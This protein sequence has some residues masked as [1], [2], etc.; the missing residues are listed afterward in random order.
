[1][2]SLR[3]HLVRSVVVARRM[4]RVFDPGQTSLEEMRRET[5]RMGERLHVPDGTVTEPAVV[6]GVAAEWVR[7]AEVPGFARQTILY[8]HSGGFCLGYG[9]SHRELAARLSAAAGTRVLAVDYRLAPE[10][11]HPAAL[12][13]CLATYRGLL[14]DGVDPESVVV[15]GDSAGAGLALMALLTLRDAG[16]PLPAAAFLLCPFGLDMVGFDGDSYESRATSD[17]MQSREIVRHYAQTY[18]GEAEPPAACI[19]QDLSGLPRL[20]IQAGDRDV[21]LSDAVRLE[22][23][24]RTAGC[25]ARLEVWPGMWHD[26]QC[27]AGIVPEARLAVANTGAFVRE[28]L[29]RAN[30][31]RPCE[32]SCSSNS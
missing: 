6:A 23:R 3:G 29:R 16:E 21:L 20:F 19:D 32:R 10:H 24:A 22:E 31:A 2:T 17:P 7:A 12:D 5:A 11:P 25:D 9:Q 14:A 18:L 27:F 15:G 28:S 26:F 30:P 8:A 1:V 4:R 13:D